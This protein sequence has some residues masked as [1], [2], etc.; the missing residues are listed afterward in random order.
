[1]MLP[2]FHT[3]H[4]LDNPPC[5]N[6]AG[7]ATPPRPTPRA[8]RGTR[9]CD[10]FADL[11]LNQPDEHALQGAMQVAMRRMDEFIDANP[12]LDPY[13]RLSL[14]RWYLNAVEAYNRLLDEE[15]GS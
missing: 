8:K 3:A 12:D 4:P 10:L 15:D 14:D 9:P 7:P 2:G 13:G 5:P 11:I 6:I 1:M